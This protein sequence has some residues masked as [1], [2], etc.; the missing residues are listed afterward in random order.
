[1]GDQS[2]VFA[3][4]P[5]V[6]SNG[7]H[8]R[9]T[10]QVA[11][12]NASDNISRHVKSFFTP[13]P[14]SSTSISLPRGVECDY[15]GKPIA[16]FKRRARD[17]FLSKNMLS[18]PFTLVAIFFS[19]SDIP[20]LVVFI[21]NLIAIV[22][23]SITLTLA[24]ERLSQELGETAGALLNITIGNLAELIILFVSL[25]H[26]IAAHVLTPIRCSV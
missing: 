21:W 8:Y 15:C 11:V 6:D 12:A 3:S 26:T 19:V 14:R 1:M 10:E 24:T 17:I 22:P 5:P 9:N 13:R 7:L 16:A 25:F 4:F 2:C 18:I 23:L 20:P